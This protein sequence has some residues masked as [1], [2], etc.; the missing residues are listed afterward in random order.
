MSAVIAT[1]KDVWFQARRERRVIVAPVL[2]ADD[3]VRVI[4]FGSRGGWVFV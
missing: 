4:R 2:M 3:R 1:F